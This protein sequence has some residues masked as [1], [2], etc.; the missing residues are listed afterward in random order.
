MS[1]PVPSGAWKEAFQF[2]PLLRQ[3]TR[4]ISLKEDVRR[5]LLIE[6]S[7]MTDRTEPFRY[8]L[9]HNDDA[10]FVAYQ[11][12]SSDGSWRRSPRG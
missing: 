9:L 10:D 3:A 8:E 12:L 7:S 4:S 11:H 6:E 2:R 5:T 1:R